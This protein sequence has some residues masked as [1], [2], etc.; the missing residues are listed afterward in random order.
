MARK[1]K[2]PRLMPRCN[3]CGKLAPIDKDKTNENWVTWILKDPCECGGIFK[4]TF[5]Y[6]DEYEE[7]IKELMNNDTKS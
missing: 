7:K 3:K 2:M 6:D 5:V 4:S 1:S